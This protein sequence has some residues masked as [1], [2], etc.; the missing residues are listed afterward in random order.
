VAHKSG[1]STGKDEL[2]GRLLVGGYSEPNARHSTR[3]RRS[4]FDA[5]ATAVLQRDVRDIANVERLS[6]MPRLL[7]L[8]ASRMSN[9]LNFSDISRTIGIPYATLN[10]YM[11]VLEATYLVGLLPAWAKSAGAKLARA[12]KVMLNDAALAARLRRADQTRIVEDGTLLDPLLETFT[13][14]AATSNESRAPS[15]SSSR[16]RNSSVQRSATEFT[17][18]SGV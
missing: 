14:Y 17:T 13:P 2:L 18:R 7:R 1:R 11:A 9:L 5:Y 6:E 16:P 12:P 8:L 15:E 4:W 3:G 10:R